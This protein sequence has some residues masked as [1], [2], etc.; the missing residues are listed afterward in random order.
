MRN[1]Y[2]GIEK[3]NINSI[4][5]QLSDDEKRKFEDLL[6]VLTITTDEEKKRKIREEMAKV[7]GVEATNEDSQDLEVKPKEIKKQQE[8]TD[9]EVMPNTIYA[10]REEYEKINEELI[11]GN[12][13]PELYERYLLL[14]AQA[15]KLG[16]EV[17][18][19][20]GVEVEND[21]TGESEKD[22]TVSLPKDIQ[23]ML[24]EIPAVKK[25]GTAFNVAI[26][27]EEYAI[28][29]E[30]IPTKGKDT[31]LDVEQNKGEEVQEEQGAIASKEDETKEEKPEV[32]QGRDIEVSY[33]DVTGEEIKINPGL[34]DESYKKELLTESHTPIQEGDNIEEVSTESS[35]AEQENT[36]R[37]RTLKEG[38][39]ACQESKRDLLQE[40]GIL[41]DEEKREMLIKMIDR[42]FGHK[43]TKKEEEAKRKA[44]TKRKELAEKAQLRRKAKEY[45]KERP[46]IEWEGEKFSDLSSRM[47][48]AEFILTGKLGSDK[49]LTAI[50]GNIFSMKQDG[51][52][53]KLEYGKGCE[54]P[55]ETTMNKGNGRKSEQEEIEHGY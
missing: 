22:E 38:N 28:L 13:S 48:I 18:E 46:V 21:K 53:I 4:S 37:E 30:D 32:A 10:I 7:I 14:K 11:R 52:M 8:K 26:T 3:T 54:N 44:E 20:I 27:P 31:K 15:E 33:E 34:I 40:F 9:K 16:E 55:F 36:G 1:T 17:V 24:D 29:L 42:L 49:L 51:K 6:R 39:T 41:P 2:E 19:D 45:I 50:G 43:E 23:E 12:R 25:G 47:A 5:L 35:I